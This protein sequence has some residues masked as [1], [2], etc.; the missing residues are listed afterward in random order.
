M[1]AKADIY[2]YIVLQIGYQLKK[3]LFI[4]RLSYIKYLQ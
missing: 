1:I 2:I 4:F 3:F